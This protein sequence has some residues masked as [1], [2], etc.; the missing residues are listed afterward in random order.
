[1]SHHK[2]DNTP[3]QSGPEE[4]A[5]SPEATPN[6]PQDQQAR[7]P[8]PTRD[9]REDLLERLQ[10]LSAE[11]LNYQKRAARDLAQAREF[12]NEDLIK[13]LLGV[14][15]DMER[16]LDAAKQNHAPD[17]PLMMGMNLVYK[18]AV[19]TLGRFGVSVIDAQGKPF[20]PELHLALMQQPSADHEPRTVLKELQRGY[21]LKGRTIRPSHVIVS[22]EVQDQP[23]QDN[24]E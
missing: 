22:Q 5:A 1:M 13:A 7:Q 14:L 8:Q 17:D 11:Y 16:G 6:E 12:A 10:R 9:E 23:G 18:K 24:K 3:E 4:Q 20:D 2:K 15:D 19:E 21:Q